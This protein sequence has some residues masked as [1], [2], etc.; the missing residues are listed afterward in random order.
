MAGVRVDGEQNSSSRMGH[1]T[2]L[3][4]GALPTREEEIGVSVDFE[5]APE[6]GA[7]WIRELVAGRD[8]D[9][10]HDAVEWGTW[11]TGTRPLTL[12]IACA[13][14]LQCRVL[15]PDRGLNTIFNRTVG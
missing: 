11:T 9:C 15:L 5:G 8:E 1:Q 7:C 12:W 14:T 4:V 10:V 6:G 2:K 13:K 3:S